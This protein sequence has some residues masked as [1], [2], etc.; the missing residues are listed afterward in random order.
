MDPNTTTPLDDISQT[1]VSP[2][3]PVNHGNLFI[4]VFIGFVLLGIGVGIG[5]FLANNVIFCS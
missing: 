5:L 3:L 1:N 4:K 2:P